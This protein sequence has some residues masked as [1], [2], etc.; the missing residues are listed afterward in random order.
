MAHAPEQPRELD[1]AQVIAELER[2]LAGE[3]PLQELLGIAAHLEAC[4]PCMHRVELRR[5]S[6]VALTRAPGRLDA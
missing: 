3:L 5:A 1:C 6:F 2:Y 4:L